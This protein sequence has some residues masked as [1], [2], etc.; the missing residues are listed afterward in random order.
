MAPAT[1]VADMFV[2]MNFLR[3]DR[4]DLVGCH[5]SGFITTDHTGADIAKWHADRQVRYAAAIAAGYISQERVD[6]PAEVDLFGRLIT[7]RRL[8]VGECSAIAVALNR[9]YG[10]ATDDPRAV[11]RALRDAGLSSN[12]VYILGTEDIV[13]TSVQPGVLAVPAANVIRFR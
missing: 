3:I 5:P 8:G 2:L 1:V 11:N 13:S 10:L 6:R 7:A 4:M 9:G 12:A